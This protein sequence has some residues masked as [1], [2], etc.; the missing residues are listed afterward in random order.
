MDEEQN[1]VGD[2][3]ARRAD[4]LFDDQMIRGGGMNDAINGG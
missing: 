4:D 1:E 2:G 3:A